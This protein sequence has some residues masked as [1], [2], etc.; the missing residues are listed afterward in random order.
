MWRALLIAEH[1]RNDSLFAR[2]SPRLNGERVPVRSD[3]FPL[4]RIL[5]N[6]KQDELMDLTRKHLAVIFLAGVAFAISSAQA[7]AKPLH[8]HKARAD[9]AAPA[10]GPSDDKY[11]FLATQAAVKKKTAV[12]RRR[13]VSASA[14]AQNE[15]VV[16]PG[17]GSSDLVAEAR[18]YIGGNPTGRGRLW[19][20]A[21]MDMV[22]K[23]TGHAGGGN[24][25]RAYARYGTR[26][27]GPQVGAIA[28]MARKGGGH[29]GVVSGIDA[30]GNP[31]IISGNHNNKVEESVY[32]RG[33]IIAYVVP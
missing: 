10:W 9:M 31:I 32:P 3:D 26:V 7:M 24:L 15:T 19:C 17:F 30:T 4:E 28:V 6:N 33:R 14:V 1:M 21:F 22:L 18:Q 29:V 25:A 16:T 8:R 20:G 5:L 23:R 13:A 12:A 27:S 2:L 11:S